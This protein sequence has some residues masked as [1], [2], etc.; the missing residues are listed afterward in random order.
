VRELHHALARYVALGDLAQITAGGASTALAAGDVF[1]EV[2]AL[3]L[4]LTAARQRVVETFERRYVERVLAKHGGNVARAAESSG[5]ARRYFQILRA[6][7]A[8]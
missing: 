5:L 6:R 3:D 1:D 4:P 7:Q 2:L 8:R